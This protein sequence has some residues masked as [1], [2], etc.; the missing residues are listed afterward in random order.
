MSLA[1]EY[2]RQLAWRSWPRI[3]SLLPA[4]DGQI[5]LDLGCGVGDQ[6]VELAARGARVIGVDASEE[7]LAVA[8]S[9]KIAN[10]EFRLGDLKALPDFDDLVDGIWCSFATAYLPELCP[11]LAR[12]RRQIKSGGWI[13]LTEIDGFFG[14]E[15]VE[16]QTSEFFAEYATDALA[17]NR[18]DFH[19]GR[20]LRSHLEQAGF[21]ILSE[22]QVPDKEL[23]F[24]GPADSEVVQA[25]LERLNRMKRLRDL[26]GSAFEHV[27]DNFLGALTRSDHRSSAKVWCCIAT[28]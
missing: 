2:Q 5:V 28:A 1:D 23:S 9:R 12:W 3:L 4:I 15:P 10:A 18:Y 27:R 16:L 24:D 20:K 22:L 17:Q 21:T 26:C 7:L 11:I 14:H 25:W 19:M 13:A 6:A 8:R